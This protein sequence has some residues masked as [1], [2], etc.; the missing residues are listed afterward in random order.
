MFENFRRFLT[1]NLKIEHREKLVKD[2]LGDAFVYGLIW[3]FLNNL[4]VKGVGNLFKE[5][6]LQFPRVINVNRFQLREFS[7]ALGPIFPRIP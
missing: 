3:D 2:V 4:L 7:D 5:S 6:F 1:K